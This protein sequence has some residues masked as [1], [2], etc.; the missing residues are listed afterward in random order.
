M[1]WLCGTIVGFLA[2][3]SGREERK[4][5]LH[6][7]LASV[8]ERDTESRPGLELLFWSRC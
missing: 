5:E 8:L 2:F 1:A 3:F 6:S 7:V 4:S